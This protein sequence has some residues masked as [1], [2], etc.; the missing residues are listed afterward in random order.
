MRRVL[1]G[2]GLSAPGRDSILPLRLGPKTL[3]VAEA[4]LGRG[5]YVAG[6]RAPTVPPG[7]ERLRIAL[8]AA[9]STEQIEA[10][11]QALRSTLSEVA[12][13]AFGTG[14]PEPVTSAE[15]EGR[16]CAGSVGGRP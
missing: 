3:P 6:I 8:S 5:F 12:P 1:E 15:P 4:L 9:H 11:G 13:E 2:L 7:T 10:F 14:G 16:A